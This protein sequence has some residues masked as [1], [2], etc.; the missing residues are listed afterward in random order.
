MC[1]PCQNTMHETK[2]D[3]RGWGWSGE[4]EVTEATNDTAGILN[5]GS[6]A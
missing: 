5:K 3:M 2:T 1:M 4:E 6:M